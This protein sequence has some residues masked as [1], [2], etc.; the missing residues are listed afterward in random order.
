MLVGVISFSYANG[1]LASIITTDDQEKQEFIDQ[2]G[3]L[4]NIRNEF[5]LPHD[6]YLS[7]K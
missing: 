3:I 7:I 2:L 1:A 5:F 6:I 4:D